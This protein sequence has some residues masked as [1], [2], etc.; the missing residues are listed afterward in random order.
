MMPNADLFQSD[1]NYTPLRAVY[2]TA[3]GA[4]LGEVAGAM[5]DATTMTTNDA[6]G[7]RVTG[8]TV[9]TTVSG[10]RTLGWWIGLFVLLGVMV[11]VARKA[12]GTE[13]F[14]NIKPTL[15]N[16]L[17]ITMT[18]IVGIVG[19]KVIFSKWRIAGFSDVILAA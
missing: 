8:S 19:F 18:A 10:A 16:F 17:A 11:W 1:I 3:A 9:A 15:Y 14:R 12:G 2:P 5:T 6:N 7:N 13:D 4:N